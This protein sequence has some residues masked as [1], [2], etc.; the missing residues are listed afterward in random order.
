LSF[1]VTAKIE[2]LLQHAGLLPELEQ[3]GCLFVVSAVE[4]LSDRV[5]A[6]LDKG[7]SRA[8]VVRALHLVRGAGIALRPSLMPFTPWSTLDDSLEL[9]D[10]IEE[11]ALA[12][13]VDEVE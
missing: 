7:H 9:F 11:H 6:I 5:L 13:A 3:L 1:D 2:H 12:G 10:F 4:S 8:D